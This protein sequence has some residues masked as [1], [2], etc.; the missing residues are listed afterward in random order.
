A[1][2]DN[3]LNWVPARLS[4]L[5]YVL[6]G[7]AWRHMG[8]W[9]AQARQWQGHNAGW[10]MACGAGGMR[11]KLGGPVVDHG[12]VEQRPWLGQGM[13]PTPGDIGRSV[14]FLQ[15]GLWL[16]LGVLFLGGWLSA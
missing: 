6:V 2:F 15:Q 12:R 9:A 14:R 4:A 3:V 11:L 13:A 7:W 8:T 5:T 10:V 1:R 16:W